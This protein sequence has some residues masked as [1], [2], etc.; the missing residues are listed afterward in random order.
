ML[1]QAVGYEGKLKMPPSGKLPADE[2]AVLKTW[3][4][5]GAVWPG[6]VSA[7][8]VAGP[9]GKVITDKDREFWAFQPV[10]RPP[11]P[12]NGNASWAS[13]DIDHFILAKL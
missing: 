4:D 6:A 5:A 12:S 10:Q 8:R 3:I 2:I 13:N 7:T 1:L 11:V 9:G